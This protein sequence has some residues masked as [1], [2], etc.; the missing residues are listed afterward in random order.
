LAI[1]RPVIVALKDG[2]VFAYGDG[3]D[4]RGALWDLKAGAW[5]ATADS[6]RLPGEPAR[7]NSP[8]HEL[9]SA[10]AY[11]EAQ[12]RTAPRM[13]SPDLSAAAP[14][15]PVHEGGPVTC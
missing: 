11:I 14:R 1:E 9:R 13:T 12:A 7:S 4:P 3:E 15:K 2:R 6:K 8:R 5:T 10:V